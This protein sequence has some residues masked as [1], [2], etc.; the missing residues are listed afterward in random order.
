MRVCPVCR[1][2]YQ[3]PTLNFCLEDGTPLQDE[4]IG[5]APPTV[6]SGQVT[7]GA[8]DGQSF[9]QTPQTPHGFAAPSVGYPPAKPK[10]SKTWLWVIGILLA[11]VV[12]CGGTFGF[13]VIVGA[14]MNDEGQENQN[15][16]ATPSP[17]TKTDLQTF[18]FSKWADGTN[19]YAELEIK[20]DTANLKST[21]S[22]YYFAMLADGPISSRDRTVSLT[23]RNSE[24]K[25][26]SLG[27]GLVFHS[28]APV[29]QRGYAFLVDA[30]RREFRIVKHE[31]KSEKPIV[32]WRKTSA[33]KSDSEETVLE[34]RD[35][36]DRLKYLINGEEVYS[37]PDDIGSSDNKVGIYANNVLVE[38]SN[39]QSWK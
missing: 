15:A 1:T 21:S 10:S 13:L 35:L 37:M 34:V 19:E 28:E 9:G 20:G 30:V 11:L 18:A 26:S 17:K 6:R 27:Y 23:V 31:N 33:M 7:F 2:T 25:K 36:G 24:G 29:L 14:L 16:S 39:L 5:E 22:L 3:D 8:N 4:S 32:A 12:G 38:F